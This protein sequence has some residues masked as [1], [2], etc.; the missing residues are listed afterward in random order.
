M[1][2]ARSI[3]FCWWLALA[4][5]AWGAEPLPPAPGRYFNDYA[6]VVSSPTA[7]RLN[8]VLEDFEKKSSSQI[9][10]V[11]Y[12]R[13]PP[14]AALED[15]TIRAASAWKAGQRARDNGAIL[16]VFPA[17]RRM[18]IEVGYGLEGALPDALAKRIIDEQIRPHFQRG[19]YDAGL[20][21]GVN[22]LLQAAQ[23]EYR[24]SGGTVGGRRS[25][26]RGTPLLFIILFAFLL[27]WFARRGRRGTV[28]H[29]G[30]RSYWGPLINT[31]GWTA[32]GSSRGG[33]SFSGGSFSG[34]GGR[35]GGGGA[36]GSW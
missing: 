15:F 4:G 30:G 14:G 11:I 23:G 21:A 2:S 18:R 34:G 19:N 36:S 32:G 33:S 13:L 10:V 17:D 12:P 16:F 7:E 29:R 9:L 6:G 31:G 5:L 28:Y 26:S 1:L 24:G 20:T 22:A 27:V 25:S 3:S 8:Q 35:F